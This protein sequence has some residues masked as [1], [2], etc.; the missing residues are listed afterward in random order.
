M[1]AVDYAIKIQEEI[2]NLMNVHAE[3]MISEGTTFEY[4]NNYAVRLV[5]AAK[6]L[7][8]ALDSTPD[9]DLPKLR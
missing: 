4:I 6:S 1:N 5:N 8:E 7:H 9:D 3:A 2:E